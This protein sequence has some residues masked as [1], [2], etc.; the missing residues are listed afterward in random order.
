MPPT[1]IRVFEP[2]LRT[3]YFI[4]ASVGVGQEITSDLSLTA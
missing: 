1:Y 2:D 4:Q 3:P